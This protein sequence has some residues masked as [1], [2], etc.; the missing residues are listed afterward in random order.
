MVDLKSYKNSFPQGILPGA[1]LLVLLSAFGSRQVSAAPDYHPINPTMSNQTITLTG[2]DLTIDELVQVARYGAKVRLSAEAK[3]R[4]SDIWDLMIEGATEGVPIYLFNRNPG[5]GREIVRFT[6]DPLSPENRPKLKDVQVLGQPQISVNPGREGD[7][8]SEIADEDVARAIM[9]VRANQMT[10]M[11]ASPQIMQALIDFINAGITPA[12]RARGS[13]GEAEGPIAVEI[14]AA[15]GGAGEAYYHG[16]R[17]STTEA[18][19]RAG[20]HPTPT[21]VGDGTTTTV[22]ADVTGPAALLVADAKR[23]LEWADIAYA[24][25][26]NGMN[27]SVTPLFTP[28]QTNRPYPWINYDAARVLDMLRGSYLLQ[29]DPKRII[30]DPESLRASYVRQGSTWEEWARLRDDVTLQMNWSDHN[31]AITVG[32]SPEDS[33]ELST[34]WAM[35]YYVKGGTES[36]GKHGFVFSNA[37]WD[38]YPLSNRVEAFTI[39]LA[40]MDIALMLRQERFQS[41]FFTLV[42]AEDVLS[43]AAVGGGYGGGGAGSWTNHEVWQRIQGLINP[44]PPEGYSGDP[45][46]VEE[47]DAETNLKVARAVQALRESWLLLASDLV[48]GARWMD[49]RKAQDAHRDFGTA[50][51]AAWQAFRRLAPLPSAAP[52]P[53]TVLP[54]QSI[55]ALAFIKATPAANFYPGGPPMP[56]GR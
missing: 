2:H 28:V 55:T 9:V 15:L 23:L 33:W 45:Q 48:V 1:G 7:Y 6:G 56:A 43:T 39:A 3:Q 11:P 12:L 34:P 51:T 8:D 10:Y 20:V 29:D 16:M 41:T 13:T 21:D 22:N 52:P 5:S 25:D 54:S 4:Q 37:N 50:P 40:N 35:R 18:L 49:V 19:R 38:P 47:L 42:H 31:P 26:L 30:Q 53:G 27:S 17:M 24:I 44:V 46:G 32:A 14:N 36:H